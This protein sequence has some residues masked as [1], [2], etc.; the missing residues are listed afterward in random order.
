MWGLWWT[1]RHWGKVFSEYFG[2]PC[3]SFHRFLHFLTGAEK[4]AVCLVNIFFVMIFKKNA[5]SERKNEYI[6]TSQN[7]S[8]M[9]LILTE[10]IKLNSSSILDKFHC[11][12]MEM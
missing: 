7:T 10:D 9:A 2:F 8:I 6:S 4:H 11:N 3:Q 5:K 12:N 1:K